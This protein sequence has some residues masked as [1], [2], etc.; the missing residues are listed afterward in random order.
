MRKT[1]LL[2]L[3]LAATASAFARDLL[4]FIACAPFMLLCVLFEALLYRC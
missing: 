1:M 4:V 2:T 3:V